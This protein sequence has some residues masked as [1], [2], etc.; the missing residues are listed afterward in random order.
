MLEK[1]LK[2]GDI[3]ID[4][5]ANYGFMSINADRLVGDSGLVIAVEPEPRARDLLKFNAELN[6]MMRMMIEKPLTQF[7]DTLASKM[8]YL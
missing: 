2:H 1:Y 8:Q 3:Y 4:I 6:M 7:L 5:G